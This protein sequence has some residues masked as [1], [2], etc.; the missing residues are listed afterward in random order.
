MIININSKKEDIMNYIHMAGHLGADPETRFT[1]NGKKITVLRVAANNRRSKK[2]ET[3]WWRVYLWGEDYN[4]II[5]YLKKGSPLI[6]VGELNKP[7]IFTDRD[8]KPR[9]SF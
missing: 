1:T 6:V 8:G 9:I 4:N 5:P 3:I 7:E 2:E